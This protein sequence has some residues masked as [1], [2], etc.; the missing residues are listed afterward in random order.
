MQAEEVVAHSPLANWLRQHA[1]DSKYW[2]QLPA[3]VDSLL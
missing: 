3:S 2:G 1:V